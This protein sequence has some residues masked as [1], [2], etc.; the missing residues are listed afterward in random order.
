VIAQLVSLKTAP[1]A[2]GEQYI[3]FPSR[4]LGMGGVSFALRD[5]LADPFRNPARG[6]WT[7]ATHVFAGPELPG[8]ALDASAPA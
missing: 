1:I 3:I 4:T 6:I 2:T 8:K 7:A 5:P